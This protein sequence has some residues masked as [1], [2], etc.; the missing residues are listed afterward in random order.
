MKKQIWLG[1][2]LVL[3]GVCGALIWRAGS[4]CLEYQGLKGEKISPQQFS[5]WLKKDENVL[6]ETKKDSFY[7]Q[8][9]IGSNSIIL[10]SPQK[11]DGNFALAFDLMSMTRSAII[12]IVV[13]QENGSEIYSFEMRQKS[14]RQIVEIRQGADILKQ[15]ESTV[16]RPDEFYHFQFEKIGQK[17][18][19]SINGAEILDTLANQAQDSG[20]ILLFVQ[21]Q[22]N[23]PAAVE[24]KN[25][26]LYR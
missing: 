17:L 22:P 5:Q 23:H 13:I 16:I 10:T 25:I 18:T 15:I 24:L 19:L 2:V 12:K 9:A 7:V 20:K 26:V 21:G 1:L 3:L 14:P 8:E 4:A 6:F 11:I